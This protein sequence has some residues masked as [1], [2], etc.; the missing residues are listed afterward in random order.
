MHAQALKMEDTA[1]LFHRGFAEVRV[2]W[3]IREMTTVPAENSK[4]QYA[5]SKDQA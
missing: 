4:K 1:Q 5:T 2:N 3:W